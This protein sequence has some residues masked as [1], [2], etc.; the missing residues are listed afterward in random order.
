MRTLSTGVLACAVLALAILSTPTAADELPYITVKL[1]DADQGRIAGTRV[2]F[3]REGQVH[4]FNVLSSRQIT[5]GD[6]FKLDL[7]ISKDRVVWASFGTGGSDVFAYDGGQVR[8]LT[9][10]HDGVPSGLHLAGKYAAWSAYDAVDDTYHEYL[11]RA[12]RTRAVTED[13]FPGTFRVRSNPQ[14]SE[15]GNMAW[16]ELEEVGLSLAYYDRHEDEV[17]FIARDDLENNFQTISGHRVAW[18]ARDTSGVPSS[19][20]KLYDGRTRQTKVLATAGGPFG[21]PV[22]TESYDHPYLVW[23]SSDGFW[24]TDVQ[25]DETIDLGAAV[26]V[27][28]TSSDVYVSDGYVAFRGSDANFNAVI[29]VYDIAR[30]QTRTVVATPAIVT[31][32]RSSGPNV[33]WTVLEFLAEEP[34]F[35]SDVYVAYRLD[36]LLER[37][38]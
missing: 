14:V 1:H 19:Q 31:S 13:F 33:V 20:L 27:N 10:D 9:A 17:R 11:N 35:R 12:R 16:P 24:L 25:S 21:T 32:M 28:L 15:D 22:F 23:Q 5:D 18:V 29:G 2:A 36:T 7:Q 34:F 3:L 4:L 37:L 26:G 38:D 8:N 6:D 30:G